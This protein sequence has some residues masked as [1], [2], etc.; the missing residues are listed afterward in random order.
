[1]ASVSTATPTET[2]QRAIAPPAARLAS[3]DLF[4]GFTIASMVM[5]NLQTGPAPYA[6][7]RHADWHGWTFTDLVFPFFLWIAGVATTLSVARR[8]ERG[9]NRRQLILHAL[10]RAALIF[11]TGLALNA[12]SNP[13]LA[14][15]RIPGVLQ[16]IA[17]CYLIGTVIFLHSGTRGRVVWLLGLFAAY[18]AMMHGGGYEKGVNFAAHVDE[19]FLSGHMWSYSKTWDPEGI[20]STLPSIGTFLFGI[21]T[22]QFLRTDRGVVEK[23]AWM[24]FGGNVLLFAGIVLDPL[25]PIN[26]SLWTVPYTLL[27]A[28]LALMVF[29]S[30]YWLV[31][32]MGWRGAWMK[33]LTIFGMNALAVYVFHALMSRLASLGGAASVRAALYGT[34]EPALGAA[35]ASLLYSLMHIGA[36]FVFAWVLWRRGWFLK[37]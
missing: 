37:F 31:D 10:R 2:E 15:L 34:F 22:G 26:K 35:N 9:E 7:L 16:R 27:T 13:D 36:S 11:L 4:R 23:T 30:C 6:P 33:P 32:A 20:V 24:L 18:T 1:M 28:G 21:L 14:T 3:L 12:T 19:M 29:G 5:V 8:V 17:V 25:Q